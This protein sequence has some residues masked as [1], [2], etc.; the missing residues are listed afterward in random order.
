MP[1]Y[2]FLA[3]RELNAGDMSAELHALSDRGSLYQGRYRQ[4]ERRP[5]GPGQ[6]GCGCHRP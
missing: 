2:Q 6:S 3:E 5:E 4:G 1:T